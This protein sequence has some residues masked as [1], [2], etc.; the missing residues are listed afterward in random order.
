M[1]CKKPYI[2]DKE[3]K[4]IHTI[5]P[6]N[7]DGRWIKCLF[8]HCGYFC[9]KFYIDDCGEGRYPDEEFFDDDIGDYYEYPRCLR[10]VAYTRGWSIKSS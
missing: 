8:G 4:P 10:M 6:N 2:G 9:R 1:L 3:P 7:Q 5:L